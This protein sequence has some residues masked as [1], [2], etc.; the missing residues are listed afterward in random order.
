MSVRGDREKF[1]PMVNSWFTDV[2]NELRP[3]G[4]MAINNEFT[5]KA[6]VLQVD[7]TGLSM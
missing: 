2:E 6:R 1:A 7:E 4:L 5:Y 3:A